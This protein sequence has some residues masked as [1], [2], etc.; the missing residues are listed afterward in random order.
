MDTLSNFTYNNGVALKKLLDEHNVEI[1]RFTDE[2]LK[3]LEAISS[4]LM[5]QMADEDDLIGRI[6][7]SFQAY[8]N[9]VKPWTAISERALLNRRPDR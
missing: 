4:E 5:Q 8:S 1:R 2:V 7:A 9:I 6:Y 3:H